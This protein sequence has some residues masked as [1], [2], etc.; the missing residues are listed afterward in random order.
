MTLD[1]IPDELKDLKNQRTFSFQ[2]N[3]VLE[4][5]NNVCKKL[6]FLRLSIC[7]I[8]T[9]S[10]SISNILPRPAVSNRLLLN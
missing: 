6:D 10:A 5:G 2:E 9:E 8:L 7:N 3:F 4:N 1:P